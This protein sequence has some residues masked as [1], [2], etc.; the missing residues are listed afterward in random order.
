MC[1]RDSLQA[2]VLVHQLGHDLP[3]ALFVA[4]ALGLDG[5]T[6]H[7]LGKVQRLEVDV[8]VLGGVV[9]HGVEMDV[10]DL[11]H[12]HDVAG[13]SAVDLDRVLALQHHQPAH[14]EGLAAV[15]DV[16]QAVLGDRAL[17]HAED[18]HAAHER[19]HRHLEDM[20]QHVQRRVGYGLHRHGSVAFALS[21]IHI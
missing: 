19:V 4:V 15:A 20:R 2:G 14:L 9:Q 5:Q 1:I 6:V 8:V 7:R 3:H 18:A 11:G 16:Q 13:A 10:V 12:G 17:V 21:L